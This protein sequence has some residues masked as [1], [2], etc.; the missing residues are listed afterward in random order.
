VI[1]TVEAP[2]FHSKSCCNGGGLFFGV[3]FRLLLLG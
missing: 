3:L 1:F 2:P